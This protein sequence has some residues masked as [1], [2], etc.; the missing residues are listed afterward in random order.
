MSNNPDENSMDVENSSRKAVEDLLLEGSYIAKHYK[1]QFIA[2]AIPHDGSEVIYAATP[3]L[4]FLLKDAKPGT[5]LDNAIRATREAK[6]A[7]ETGGRFAGRVPTSSA[8]REHKLYYAQVS[9]PDDPN[10]SRKLRT[11]L[12]CE[13]MPKLSDLL[14]FLDITTD[15]VGLQTWTCKFPHYHSSSK[16]T[17]FFGESGAVHHLKKVHIVV[18]KFITG[19]VEY[20]AYV[21]NGACGVNDCK[22]RFMNPRDLG[23]HRSQRHQ[24][25]PSDPQQSTLPL[26]KKRSRVS[27][28]LMGRHSMEE[29]I[30]D[31]DKLVKRARHDTPADAIVIDDSED[32][33]EL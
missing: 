17:V 7:L 29:D 10:L 14:L 21:C 20:D 15:S 5:R 2:V 24:I 22:R 33:M 3:G 30:S 16:E 8:P 27:D 32:D 11:M 25:G 13:E 31:D 18:D 6:S 19:G 12:T 26:Q 28:Q 4:Q 23:N 9:F 1:K